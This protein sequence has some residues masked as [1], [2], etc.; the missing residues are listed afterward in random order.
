MCYIALSR[1]EALHADFSS[2][3]PSHQRPPLSEVQ[4]L[5]G[6]ERPHITDDGIVLLIRQRSPLLALGTQRPVGHA[7]CLLNDEPIRVYVPLL[8]HPWILQASNS[9]AF[10]H[11][12]TARTLRVLEFFY[13]WMGMCMCTR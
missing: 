10:C 13:W 7:A 4:D 8:M 1:P 3:F 9:I 6:K 5:A 2:C 12:G 11:Q